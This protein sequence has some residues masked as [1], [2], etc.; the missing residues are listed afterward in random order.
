MPLLPSAWGL[1]HS[2][3]WLSACLF[4]RE[5]VE[6]LPLRDCAIAIALMLFGLPRHLLHTWLNG[7]FHLVWCDELNESARS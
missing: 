5:L 2:V 7:Q 4:G 3:S 1:F 6:R